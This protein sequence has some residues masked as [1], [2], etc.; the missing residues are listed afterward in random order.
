M[1]TLAHDDHQVR[2][3]DAN[4]PM[5]GHR[6]NFQ[7]HDQAT[8]ILCDF[9][10]AVA[11]SEFLVWT[12]A[13]GRIRI[14]AGSGWVTIGDSFATAGDLGAFTAGQTRAATVEVTV[15]AG[16]GSRHEELPLNINLG[17]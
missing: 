10:S 4:V 7:Q 14:N 17:V 2:L 6:L 8:E 15:P 5:R 11:V 13:T 16:S 1:P 12:N 9:Y 3:R